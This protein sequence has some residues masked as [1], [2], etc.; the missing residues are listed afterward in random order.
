L[1]PS[2]RYLRLDCNSIGLVPTGFSRLAEI[3]LLNFSSVPAP[4]LTWRMFLVQEFL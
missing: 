3:L 2:E 1:D 4:K